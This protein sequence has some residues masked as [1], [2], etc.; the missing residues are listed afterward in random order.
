[1]TGSRS[2]THRPPR[3]GHPKFTSFPL[4][5]Y[6]F[7]AVFDAI[8]AIGGRHHWASQLWH[9]GTFVLIGGLS[10]CLVTMGTGLV[11]LM[12]FW[13]QTNEAVQVAAGHVG[14][15]AAAFMIGVGDIAWRL[16]DFGSRSSAPPGVAA[17]SAAAAITAC[18]GGYLGGK[19]VFGH[20]V[21]VAARA[22]AVER[23]WP[24]ERTAVDH[25]QAS[26][27]QATSGTMRRPPS[28]TGTVM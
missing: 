26:G 16:S 10:I 2:R 8:S 28:G 6:V 15:M 5:A 18:T 11:D 1:M 25:E 9:A 14:V 24:G 27:G 23:R 12:R 3:P 13:P 4:A 21:G 7:A 19:L 20:G 22:Q 17:L